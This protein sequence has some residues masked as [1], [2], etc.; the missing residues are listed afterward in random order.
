MIRRLLG[1]ITS[2]ADP[3]GAGAHYASAMAL[4]EEIGMQPL[5]AHCHA[6]LAKRY[7]STCDP[8]AAESHFAIAS[9]LFREMGMTYWLAQAEIAM[10]YGV[11]EPPR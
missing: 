11:A 8:R 9:A 5:V 4:A 6:S 10:R 3:A 7:R 2:S 1:E